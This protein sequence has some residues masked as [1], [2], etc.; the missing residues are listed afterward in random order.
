VTPEERERMNTLC[1]RIALE[2][3]QQRFTQLLQELNALLDGKEQRL[4]TLHQTR[5]KNNIP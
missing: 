2:T 1:K 4:N 5:L 3:D